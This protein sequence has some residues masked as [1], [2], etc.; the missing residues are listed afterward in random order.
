M[1]TFYKS[2]RG[3]CGLVGAIALVA[4][5]QP[6]PLPASPQ[7]T[8]NKTPTL[9]APPSPSPSRSSTKPPQATPTTPRQT[10]TPTPFHLDNVKSPTVNWAS[11][12]V[13]V[14]ASFNKVRY[15]A[16][17]S[18]ALVWIIRDTDDD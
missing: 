2:I 1:S 4:C 6:T 8:A 9:Q 17:Q 7:A 16:W 11:P 18:E 3:I 14:Q 13:Q 5:A 15:I 10:A 12:E